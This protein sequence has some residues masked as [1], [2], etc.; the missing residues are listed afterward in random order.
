MP[1]PYDGKIAVWHVYGGM[2]GES[3]IEEIATTLRRFAPAV[4]AVFVKVTDGTDWMGSFETAQNSDLAINGPNDVNRWVAKL[5][6]YNLD[7]HAWALPKGIDPNAEADLMIQVCQQRGVRSLILDVEGGTG[8]FRGGRDMIRPLMT[9][10]RAGLPA[11]FHIGLSIDPRPNHY[12]EIYPDEWRPFV[13]SVHP[14][15]YWKAFSQ[16]P[17]EALKSA[18]AVWGK[19]GC[20]VIPVLQGYEVDRASMDRARNLAFKVYNAAGVSWYTLGGIGAAQF[21]A[22]NVRPGESN[23][24]G[25]ETPVTLNLSGRYENEIIVKPDDAAYRDGI[26]GGVPNPFQTFRNPNGWTSKFVATQKAAS[27]V[28]ARWDPQLPTG[29]FWEISAHVPSQHGTTDNARYKIHGIDGVTGDYEATMRQSPLDDVWMPLGVFKFRANDPT[30]GVVLLNDLTGEDGREIA[31]DAI[32]WRQVVGIDNPPPYLADG[33]DSPLGSAADRKLDKLWP[34][35]WHTTNPFENFYYLGPG[36]S[37][38]ALHTGTDMILYDPETGTRQ[39]AA[40]QPVFATASGLVTY[41]ERATGSWGNVIVVQHD[42]LITT[43]QVISSRYGHVENVQVKAG[44]RVARGQ[45]I[46]NVGNAFGR[47]I[48]HLHF[49]LSHTLILQSRPWDWPGLNKRRLEANYIDPYRFIQ[50]HRPANP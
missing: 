20:P 11:D 25:I 10:L 48:Y 47:F 18:Y 15:V 36:N 29:G 43:G 21:P 39:D 33:F 3:T 16:S 4:S 13:N 34:P 1:T 40:H 45:H 49:D 37:N 26:F 19:Y 8:F 2:V 50:H 9:R 41:S 35:I 30:A 22:V 31:F 6:R 5:G 32:R 42:P 24:P 17:D 44:D 46:A 7:F 27:Y 14:Q 12:D 38:P 28:W 23:A